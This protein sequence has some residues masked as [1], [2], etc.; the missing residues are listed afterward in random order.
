MSVPFMKHDPSTIVLLYYDHSKAE[1]EGVPHARG[2]GLHRRPP[3]GGRLDSTGGNRTEPCERSAP[4][5]PV[6]GGGAVHVLRPGR[7]DRL[8]HRRPGVGAAA[9]TPPRE[10]TR[11]RQAAR[12]R[13]DGGPRPLPSC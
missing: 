5:A 3:G 13:R 2:P 9:R 8:P 10:V 1:R 12:V 11:R 4:A 6:G 7:R